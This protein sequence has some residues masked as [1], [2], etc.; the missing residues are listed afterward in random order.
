MSPETPGLRAESP[1][2]ARAP[3]LTRLGAVTAGTLFAI[4]GVIGF[5]ALVLGGTADHAHVPAGRS[6]AENKQRPVT[7]K[8]CD[9]LGAGETLFDADS[10]ELPRTEVLLEVET[11]GGRRTME[12]LEFFLGK[13][14]PSLMCGERSY[15]IENSYPHVSLSGIAMRRASE[16]VHSIR[17][18]KH[19]LSIESRSAALEGKRIEASWQYVGPW[20]R[21][22]REN[23]R[24]T[25]TIDMFGMLHDGDGPP[26]FVHHP[27][28]FASAEEKEADI[29]RSSLVGL[30]SAR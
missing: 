12:R 19:G 9:Q 1:A 29:A 11:E 30:L 23:D 25:V 22:L 14:G 15:S 10:P 20:V 21:A 5:S 8:R 13:R 17:G 4:G 18:S 16:H 3:R 2:T 24:S 27:V 28:R 26:R 7:A 6:P